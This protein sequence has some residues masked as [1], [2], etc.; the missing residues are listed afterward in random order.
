M[1]DIWS[2]MIW[3]VTITV[4]QILFIVVPLLV[5]VAYVTYA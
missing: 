1:A 4:L 2:G 3:P 5:G